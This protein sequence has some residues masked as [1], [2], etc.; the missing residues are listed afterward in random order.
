MSP[1]T[2][3]STNIKPIATKL[4][5]FNHKNRDFIQEN[6]NKLLDE[7]IVRPSLSPWCAQLVVFKN[8]LNRHKK[9][10]CVDNSQTNTG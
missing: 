3:I 1:F 10:M 5:R 6:I 7:V 8:A 9:R 2:N 4:R